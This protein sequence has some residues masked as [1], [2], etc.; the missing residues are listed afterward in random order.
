MNKGLK[1][2]TKQLTNQIGS[3]TV[4]VNLFKNDA[5]MHITIPLLS[6][7]G[8]SAFSA[9]LVYNHQSK[10]TITKAKVIPVFSEKVFI[11][12]IMRK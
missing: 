5:N 10:F 3:A 1:S 12:I 8:L 2:Y 7:T 9:S 11:L 6:T 4:N